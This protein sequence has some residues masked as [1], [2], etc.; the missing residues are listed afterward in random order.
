MPA[1]RKTKLMKLIWKVH[2]WIYQQTG[3]RIGARMFGVPI[4]LLTTKGRRTGQA[5][6][7]PLMYLNKGQSWVVAASYAGEPRHPA[8]WLNLEAEPHAQIQ[9]RALV[10]R[11]V[12]RETEGEEREQLWLEIVQQDRSFAEYQRRTIRR[13]PVVILEPEPSVTPTGLCE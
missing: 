9:R 7:T 5:R 6:T 12:A 11:V 10:T 13:I 4:L 8:W 3:G 2:P 1:V